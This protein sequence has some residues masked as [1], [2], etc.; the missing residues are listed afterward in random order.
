MFAVAAV[1]SSGRATSVAHGGVGAFSSPSAVHFIGNNAHVTLC[2]L[3]LTVPPTTFPFFDDLVK[4]SACHKE[5]NAGS[6]ELAQLATKI[7]AETPEEGWHRPAGFIIHAMRVGST[8]VANMVGA[9]PDAVV[10]KE[11]RALTDVLLWADAAPRTRQ[12]RQHAIL[13]LRAVVHLFFRSAASQR[14]SLYTQRGASDAI[15]R[16][17][18]TRLVFKLSSASTASTPQLKLLR[19]AFPEVSCVRTR[20]RLLSPAPPLSS[21]SLLRLLSRS[22]SPPRALSPAP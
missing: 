11:A 21:A 10:V 17:G 12:Q 3:N 20:L 15:E 2:G 19:A 16:A 14:L 9:H 22:V 7:T 13:A 4:A 5:S 8:A 1:P 6:V 18:A